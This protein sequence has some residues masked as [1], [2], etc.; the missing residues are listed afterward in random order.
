MLYD[1][2]VENWILLV[3]ICDRGF[4]DVPLTMLNTIIKTMSEIFPCLM[5]KCYLLR[6]SQSLKIFWNLIKVVIDK[7]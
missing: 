7:A 5:E 1:N 6:Y 2:K 4:H 3:D